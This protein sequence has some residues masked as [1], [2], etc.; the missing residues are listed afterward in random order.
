MP[1]VPHLP[2]DEPPRERTPPD[3]DDIVERII[4]GTGSATG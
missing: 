3:I 2:A 1:V 4:N